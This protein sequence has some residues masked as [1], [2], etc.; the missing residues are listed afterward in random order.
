M[1]KNKIRHLKFKV[2]TKKLDAI[3]VEI[4][5]SHANIKIITKDQE[6][7]NIKYEIIPI[8]S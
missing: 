6:N 5:V 4:I 8:P 1:M 2:D 7:N 3:V